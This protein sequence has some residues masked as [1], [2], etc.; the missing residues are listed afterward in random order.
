MFAGTQYPVL[1]EIAGI[2][3]TY[4]DYG[5]SRNDMDMI[6]AV[7]MSFPKISKVTLFGSRAK[8][9]YKPGSDV[10]LAIEAGPNGH[11]IATH[12]AAKL[13][14]DSPLPYM[15]DVIDLSTITEKA[16]LEHIQRVGKVIFWRQAA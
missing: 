1:A 15:F 7:I 10:D 6:I 4:S 2:H 16:L 12:L 11:S 5:L 8:G 9:N 13:N 14:E 3:M